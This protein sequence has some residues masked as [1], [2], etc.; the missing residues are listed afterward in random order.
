M[1]H[2]EVLE[3]PT[4]L[5]PVSRRSSGTCA[6]DKPVDLR[7]RTVA[8]Q[9]DQR[10]RLTNGRNRHDLQA[11]RRRAHTLAGGQ[12]GRTRSL[13]S[14]PAPCCPR[15]SRSNDPPPSRP[16]SRTINRNGAR[17]KQPQPWAL[18]ISLPS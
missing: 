7:H 6:H 18:T 15:E 13:S 11:D 4:P 16:P 5:L 14:V 8:D 3:M 2:N 9:G 10:P 1:T 12:R 17:L